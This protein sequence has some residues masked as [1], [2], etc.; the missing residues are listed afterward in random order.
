MGLTNNAG[1]GANWCGRIHERVN[2]IIG[3]ADTLLM[4]L[5]HEGTV[6]VFHIVFLPFLM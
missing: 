5:C 4:V 1:C 6:Y 2:S 3:A